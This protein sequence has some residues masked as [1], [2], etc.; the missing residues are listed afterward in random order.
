[1]SSSGKPELDNAKLPLQ[2]R[3]ENPGSEVRNRRIRGASLF[4]RREPEPNYFES[5]LV[6]GVSK[7]FKLTAEDYTPE[8][9][10]GIGD[11]ITQIIG[12]IAMSRF[13]IEKNREIEELSRLSLIICVH[14]VST[15]TAI[16]RSLPIELL[17]IKAGFESLHRSSSEMYYLVSD[18]Q[19]AIN[20]LEAVIA[21]MDEVGRIATFTSHLLKDENI[22]DMI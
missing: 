7:N 10:A 8:K 21:K 17:H 16:A 3:L 12:L 4:T 1:M 6:V 20:N 18:R 14:T 19:N 15:L 5:E 2:H 9:L 22:Q 13:W 11:I